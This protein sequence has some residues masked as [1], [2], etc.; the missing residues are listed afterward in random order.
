MKKL[1]EYDSYTSDNI[2]LPRHRNEEDFIL[3]SKLNKKL[4]GSNNSL[5]ETSKSPRFSSSS[6]LSRKSM[7]EMPEPKSPYG[8]LTHQVRRMV[9]ETIAC[10]IGCGGTKCKYDNG[11]WPSD[12]MVL[13]GLYSNWL[14]INL[15]VLYL[16]KKKNSIFYKMIQQFDFL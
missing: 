7:A 5:N 14:I 15:I 12:Q 1:K 10:K 11:N 4:N 9:P 8:K 13:N 2:P 6:T 16:K 3:K